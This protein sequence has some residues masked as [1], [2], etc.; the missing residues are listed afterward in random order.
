MLRHSFLIYGFPPFR[1]VVQGSG[2][3]VILI[4][5]FRLSDNLVA[6]FLIYNR[7]QNSYKL[8]SGDVILWPKNYS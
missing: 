5:I 3:L 1:T 2:G 4:C 7:L 8:N 6:F